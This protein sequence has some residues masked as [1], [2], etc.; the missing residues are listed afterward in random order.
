MCLKYFLERGCTNLR[1]TATQIYSSTAHIQVNCPANHFH[2]KI[3]PTV[4]QFIKT[5]TD[6]Y[7]FP[8]YAPSKIF[9]YSI[10]SWIPTDTVAI[11]I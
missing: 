2:K 3:N 7:T 9:G 4:V 1:T 6:R 5:N 10:H 11:T 8:L